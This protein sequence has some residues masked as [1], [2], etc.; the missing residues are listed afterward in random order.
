MSILRGYKLKTLFS[1]VI[2]SFIFTIVYV[3]PILGKNKVNND[4]NDILNEF[5]NS[6]LGKVLINYPYFKDRS[7]GVKDD[8]VSGQSF[9]IYY[10]KVN[11]YE[12]KKL[13]S[14]LYPQLNSIDYI[15]LQF[16]IPTTNLLKVNYL[17]YE[18]SQNNMIYKD[19]VPSNRLDKIITVLISM[20]PDQ[21]LLLKQRKNKDISYLSTILNQ[22]QSQSIEGVMSIINHNQNILNLINEIK[23]VYNK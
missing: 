5:S 9:I 19:T 13:Y 4:N 20:Y 22:V 10:G 15:N 16:Y 2:L 6:K 18:I 11:I 21:E 14:K 8:F 12:I 17:H 23:K 7:G 3:T 1:L